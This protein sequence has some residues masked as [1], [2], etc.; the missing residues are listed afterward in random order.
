MP[1]GDTSAALD[2]AALTSL[3][4]DSAFG[5]AIGATLSDHMWDFAMN[6]QYALAGDPNF[7]P[8]DTPP[9]VALVYEEGGTEV[10]DRCW[11]W[12]TGQ[13]FALTGY[14][15]VAIADDGHMTKDEA[16]RLYDA[17]RARFADCFGHVK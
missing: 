17:E 7:Y 10:Y 4:F 9:F 14:R 3:G 12:E 1:N 16:Q 8:D 5:R 15:V 11:N 2:F 6:G 13:S